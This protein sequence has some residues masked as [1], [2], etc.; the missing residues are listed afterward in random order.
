MRG[1]EI[2]LK[3]GVLDNLERELDINKTGLT[4]FTGLSTSQ[5]Y[6]VRTGKSKVG[7]DFIAGLLNADPSKKFEDFFV[8]VN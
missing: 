6:R 2:K 7:V 5:I 3:P 8:I 4:V 1:P